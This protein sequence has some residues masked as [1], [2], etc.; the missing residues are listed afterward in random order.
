MKSMLRKALIVACIVFSG[1]MLSLFWPTPLMATAE[2]GQ[3]TELERLMY[4]FVHIRSLSS[5]ALKRERAQQEQALAEHKSAESR[6]KVA[7]LLSLPTASKRDKARALEL[8]RDSQRAEQT[9][10]TPASSLAHILL[11]MLTERP[12]DGPVAVH[13]NR[14]LPRCE[15]QLQVERR[16]VQKLQTQIEELKELEKTLIERDGTTQQGT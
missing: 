12:P 15:E 14:R 9:A 7:L 1:V 13:K 8:L 16:N 6:F 3:A 10:P 2:P 4:Y 5:E 11:T